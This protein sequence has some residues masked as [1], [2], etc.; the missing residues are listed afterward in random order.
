MAPS[1][2]LLATSGASVLWLVGC[3]GSPAAAANPTFAKAIAACSTSDAQRHVMVD[4]TGSYR[5][6]PAV[7]CLQVGGSVTWKNTTGDL[8][9]TSTD[10]PSLAA[11]ADDATIPRGGHGWDLKLPSGRSGTLTFRTVGVYH[12]FCI[13]HETLGMVGVVDVVR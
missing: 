7:V 4:A 9:H 10:E 2:A 5:F 11:S 13:P 6:V 8:D 12:Y 1:L 3:A